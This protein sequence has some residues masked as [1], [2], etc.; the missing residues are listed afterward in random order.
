MKVFHDYIVV[1]SGLAGLTFSLK[2][3]EFGS[4]AL[5]T[6]DALEESA[7][8]YAQGGIA[9]VMA[10]DDSFDLHVSDTLE[11]GRGLCK[12]DVVRCI[13]REGPALVRELVDLGARFTRTP[14]DAYHL[15]REGGHSKHRILHADD[16]TGLEI[17]RTLIQAIRS[18][19]NIE[20][21][22]HHMAVDIITRSNLDPKVSPG[23]PEDAALRM[24]AL[25][26]KVS[27]VATCLGQA[28]MLA[29]I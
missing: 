19:P 6:K 28:V 29:P 10:D 12:E 20:I 1:G 14:E 18:K 9:S 3:S 22:T 23:S 8:K 7:T 16:I 27:Q 2:I 13:V 5:I 24:Y 17:E 21:F 25:N 11:A 15:T 26:E 4:V